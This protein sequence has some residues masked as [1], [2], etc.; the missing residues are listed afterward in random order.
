M[1]ENEHI[2]NPSGL[3]FV[4]LTTVHCLAIFVR[5]HYFKALVDSLLYN[6][7]EKDLKL[8]AWCIMPSELLLVFKS[9][10]YSP[11]KLLQEFKQHTSKLLLWE[12]RNHPKECRKKMLLYILGKSGK[13]IGQE[14]Q[15]W[16]QNDRYVK[17][18]SPA[19]IA[20]KIATIHQ[21]PLL[22]GFV[23]DVQ[24]WKFSSAI[25]FHH[26]QGLLPLNKLKK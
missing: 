6:I 18:H 19:E 9:E 23:S 24:H 21:S 25:D 16:Q 13:L 14:Y 4:S 11:R 7:Q 1:A 26:G 17:L 8:Y 22:A 5:E 3:Y 2:R 20:Q 15:F 10:I 12:I